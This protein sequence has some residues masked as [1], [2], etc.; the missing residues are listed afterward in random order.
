MAL[1][2]AYEDGKYESDIYKLWEKSPVCKADPGS[3]KPHF[4]MAMPPPNETSTLHLGGAL[5]LTLQDIIARYERQKGKDGL[6]L[7]GTDHAAIATNAVVEKQ[8]AEQGTNKHDIGR[9]EFI[10]RV[11][12]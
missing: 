7:P 11:K 1:P 12:D 2:K 10:S 4:S 3:S 5:F 9:E 6:W 8:L